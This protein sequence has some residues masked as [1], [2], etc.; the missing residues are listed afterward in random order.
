MDFSAMTSTQAVAA[1]V[2]GAAV[3]LAILLPLMRNVRMRP[4]WCVRNGCGLATGCGCLVLVVIVVLP[5]FLQWPESPRTVTCFSN[6]RQLA[7]ASEIYA[8]DYD[9]RMLP[10]AHWM[11]L[12]L[13][14]VK[15]SDIYRCPQARDADPNAYG[16]S[17]NLLLARR[18]MSRVPAPDE[19]LMVYDSEYLLRNATDAVTSLP[20]PGR[21]DRGNIVSYVDGH[22]KRWPDTTRFAPLPPR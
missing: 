17:F 10:S 3:V 7:L 12:L 13:P 15:D 4:T 9:H 8:E 18:P 6:L 20:Q 16:Y 2:A 19:T 11:D 22:V 14:Y 1:A 5:V 21:H